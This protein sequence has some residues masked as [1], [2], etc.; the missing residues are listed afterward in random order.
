MS[1]MLHDFD[2]SEGVARVQSFKPVGPVAA[3]FR[4]DKTFITSIMGPY[5]SAK[6]TTCFQKIINAAMWQRPD[7]DG[8][9]HSR[10]MVVRAT[11][12]QLQ[13]NVM[14][15]WF[16]WFPKTAD[17]W[18]GDKMEHDLW[19][20]VPNFGTL[21]IQVLFRA[22][23]DEK[24]AEALFKGVNLTWVWL[25]EVDT[26]LPSVLRFALPRVGRF[27][28]TR[29]GG[30]AWS[31]VFADMNAPD[32]DNWTYDLLVNRNMGIAEETLQVFRDA[33]GP[34]FGIGFHR[35]PGGLEPGAENKA[36]LPPGYY[37]RLMMTLS[38]NDKRRF[39]DNEFGAVRSGQPVYPEFNDRFHVATDALAALPGKG[40]ILALDGG[41]TPAAVLLQRDDA[42]Q[43]RVLDE[44]V[45][46]SND[47]QTALERMGP[48]GFARIVKRHMDDQWPKLRIDD[49]V[50][51]PAMF[52]GEHDDDLA[53]AS[54][55]A[56]EFGRKVRPAPVKGNRITPRLEAVRS[57]LVQNIG[58]NPG[59]LLSPR[60]K[61]LRQGFN[62]GYVYTRIKL[63]TAGG[64]W[65]DEPEKNDFS[66]V[67]DALQ[68]GCCWLTK[69]GQASED[70]DE[71]RAARR[72][73][74][75]KGRGRVQLGDYQQQRRVA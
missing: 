53:W 62:A 68:Y 11:Y 59:F 37:E 23:E 9:R 13:T 24:R 45:V 4:D 72:A 21:H 25:N 73:A 8:V 12:G 69:K 52:Y 61:K 31:G 7:R 58:P 19:L 65:K 15:D 75:A 49:I 1:A 27:P 70:S 43:I 20:E 66:H 26:L 22:C 14:E 41:T 34:L 29:E 16:A 6:T 40:A 18:N 71:E 35:Q 60:C 67:H 5:G 63:S 55:F 44:I 28:G 39:V 42:G 48:K 3:R 38:A 30:C 54:D 17:N 33:Y 56:A 50:G 32:V 51:D 36:N 64:R 10:G 2:G 57:G 47:A 46:F 74:R